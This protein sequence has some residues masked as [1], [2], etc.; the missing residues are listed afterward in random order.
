MF[1]L[2]QNLDSCLQAASSREISHMQV[3]QCEN[4]MGTEVWVIVCDEHGNGGTGKYCG[5]SDA[6]LGRSNVF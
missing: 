3:N 5:Y 4:Q 1:C 2:H 6:H